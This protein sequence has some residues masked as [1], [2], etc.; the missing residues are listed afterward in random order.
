MWEE[1]RKHARNSINKENF[2]ILASDI[3]GRI[4][5]TA[6]DNAEKAGV[7]DYIAFQR[8]LWKSLNQK[9]IWIYNN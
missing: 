8:C 1:V 6:R 9:E 5:K 2:R 3:N 7:S 4:L